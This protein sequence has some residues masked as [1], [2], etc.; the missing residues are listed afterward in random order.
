M[1][2]I[3][4]NLIIHTALFFVCREGNFATSRGK[5][6]YLATKQKMAPF[7]VPEIL[8]FLVLI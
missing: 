3:W 6:C 4:I 7:L 2:C 1:I 8:R 5:F